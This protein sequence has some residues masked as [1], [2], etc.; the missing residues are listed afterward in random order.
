VSLKRSYTLLAPVYD[1]VAGPAFERARRASLAPLRALSPCDVLLNGVGTGLDLPYLSASHRYAALDL[2]RAMIVRGLRR[3]GA[4]D[5]SWIQGDSEA[6][7]FPGNTF[8]CAVL[9]LIIAVVPHPARA[10]REAARVV[11][12]G[13][14]LLLFDKFLAAGSSA[15]LRR[16]LNP[17]VSRIATR[18]DVVF[19]ALIED[20]PRLRVISNEPAGAGGWFRRIVLEK[21]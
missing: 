2:T 7:P 15:P 4:L 3:A 10:L 11:K 20:E 6:L 1:L 14:T 5:I 12:S 8:D 19:E 18:T 17:L 16:L 21:T 13:G 9:H